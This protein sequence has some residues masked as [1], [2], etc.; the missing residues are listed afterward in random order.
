[1]INNRPR[2]LSAFFL[3]LFLVVAASGIPAAGQAKTAQTFNDIGNSPAEIQQAIA[4]ASDAGYM[5][6][7]ADGGFHP[8]EGTSR[9]DA[10]RALVLIFKHG[11]EDPDPSITFS[12]L[13]SQ[14][15]N[16]RWANLAVKYGLMDGFPDGSF[17][18]NEQVIFERVAIGITAGMGLS[19]VAQNINNLLGGNPYYG[20]CMTVFM[21]LHCKYR[22]SSVWPGTP[23]PRG[24]MAFSLQRLD[25]MES[26]RP[27]YIRA[28]F[29]QATC[30]LPAVSQEQIKAVK[31]G[32]E[33]LGCPY[34][35]GGESQAEGGFD[36][37][38]FVYNTLS[39]R[40]GYPMMRVADDQGRDDR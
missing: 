29:T 38:G 40:M 19:D 15:G 9:I 6:G 4:Y 37:S 34:L 13:S 3:A 21:D 5:Q 33:R 17:R 28:S 2:L 14:D 7:F 26:W 32:F 10:A 22:F 20:G 39:M 8:S 36:C 24:E 31:L 35:Y 27:P 30:N 16:Y 18:P 25:N 1:M 23:Y 12:D 11:N